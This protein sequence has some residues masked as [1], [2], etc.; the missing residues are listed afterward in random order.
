VKSSVSAAAKALIA[1]SGSLD[2]G[3]GAGLATRRP[4]PPPPRSLV[5]RSLPASRPLPSLFSFNAHRH[6]CLEAGGHHLGAARGHGVVNSIGEAALHPTAFGGP[7]SGT[8][9]RPS[10]GP[11]APRLP[12]SRLQLT[13]PS[14][15]RGQALRVRASLFGVLLERLP[16]RRESRRGTAIAASPRHIPAV[17]ATQAPSVWLT[18]QALQVRCRRQRLLSR[19]T[20][21]GR[22]WSCST[23][24]ADAPV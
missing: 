5:R 3:A 6:T 10:L 15:R 23:R 11:C 20:P 17:G 12:H 8:V 2:T 22:V 4:P 1:V 18:R 14:P 9:W 13:A 24:C 16:R 19:P 21:W 7:A